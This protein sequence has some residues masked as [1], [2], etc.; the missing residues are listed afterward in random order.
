MRYLYGQRMMTNG[1]K[2][3]A[4]L[5]DASETLRFRD[6]E[7]NVAAYELRRG[8]RRVRL[9]RQPMDLL[10][11]LVERRGQLVSRNDIV[12]R[13]WGKDVFVDV[14]TGVHRA[15]LKVRQALRDSPDSPAFVETIS[16]KGYRFIAPV[17]VVSRPAGEPAASDA[18][19]ASQ[20][21]PTLARATAESALQFPHWGR[22]HVTVLVGLIGVVL[23][24]V[25][26][27]VWRGSAWLTSPVTLAVLPFE[28]LTQRPDSA[29]LSDGLTEETVA[30]LGQFDPGRLRVVGRTS[31]M[32]Y[33]GTTKSLAEIGRELVVDYLVEGSIRAEGDRLR[34]TSKLIRVRDQVQVWS[35]SYDR[36]PTS[37]LGVQQ[38]LSTAIAEQIQRRLSPERVTALA[39]RQTRNAD[40]YDLYLRGENLSKQRTPTTNRRAIEYYER[41]IALDPVYALAWSGIARTYSASTINADTAP[42]EV[43]P[44]ALDAARQAV[45]LAPDLAEAQLALGH[46]SWFGWDWPTAET[47][48]RRAVH[49]DPSSAQAHYLLGHALSQSRRH[50]EARPLMARARAL[51][52]LD[53]MMHAMSAQVA[54]QAR[55]Y[56][57]ALEHARHAT[58]IDP[59]FWIG[60]IGLANAHLQLGRTD[61]ALETL[62]KVRFP[63]TGSLALRGYMFAKQGHAS[64]ARDVLRALEAVARDKYVPPSRVAMVHAGLGERE[65]VFDWL[66]KA[67][68]VRDV[69]L[70]FLPVNPI[71][72]PYRTDPRF[73]AL[74]A[75]CGFTRNE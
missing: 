4:S 24:I 69:N 21:R 68:V 23:V 72:D 64:E 18:T 29:Y 20:P 22:T 17:E 39:Q 73:G 45:R 65:A 10:I 12:E 59:E 40:A 13:L 50:D 57:A 6:V 30:S 27:L 38:E 56:H 48:F 25:F 60:H 34:I 66:E 74:L 15:I 70:I 42:L 8:G 55:D 44:R 52:P 28:N 51:D 14:E 67:Y 2:R 7:L 36:E 58:V 75:R 35:A 62:T 37:M 1:L 47:A 11:L 49:L 19:A 71:W 61:V 16:G 46:V 26:T 5:P 3:K 43:G 31:T 54:F 9:E 53:P 32:A 41:A 33:K 63:G